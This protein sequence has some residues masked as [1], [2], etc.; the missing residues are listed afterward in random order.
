MAIASVTP[1]PITLA[2]V[3]DTLGAAN[4]DGYRIANPAA[5]AWIEVNNGSGGSITVTLHLVV[6]IDGVAV[7][8]RDVIIPAGTRRKIGVFPKAH[9]NDANGDVLITFSAV[10]SVTFGA[11][12][13]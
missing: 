1:T 2:G 9:Y 12:T 8:P 4:T 7:A 11:W 10:T 5:H 6:E 3:A 13:I